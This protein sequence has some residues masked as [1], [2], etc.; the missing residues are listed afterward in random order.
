MSSETTQRYS[1][2]SK[3][4]SSKLVADFVWNLSASG[5]GVL[6][7]LVATP[8]VVH[9]LGPESYGVY[10]LLGVLLSYLAFTEIGLGRA[11]ERHGAAALGKGETARLRAYFG[12]ALTLQVVIGLVV[13]LMIASAGRWALE[14][15]EI[16]S[17]QRAPAETALKV[18]AFSFAINLLLG[19]AQAPLRA[20][21]A[22]S[23]LN[24]ISLVAQTV[25]TALTV[26][27][28][29][30]NPT[31]VSLVTALA[32][33]SAFRLLLV[34]LLS[35]RRVGLPK[36]MVDREILRDLLSFGGA[37]SLSSILSPILAH[38]EKLLL[39]ALVGTTTL[40]F[41]VVPF[42]VLSK[43]G[44]VSGSLARALFPLMS[45]MEGEGRQ[46][47]MWGTNVRATELLFWLLAPVFVGLGVTG[48]IL[49]S[50]WMGAEFA[51]RSAPVLP[52]LIGGMFINLLAWNAVGL[53]QA[54][55]RPVL[56]AGAYIIEAVLYLPLAWFLM[57]QHGI[58]GAAMAWAFRVTLDAGILWWIARK[59]FPDAQLRSPRSRPWALPVVALVLLL[60]LVLRTLVESGWLILLVGMLLAGGTF[61]VAWCGGLTPGERRLVRA[62]AYP[63]S[64]QGWN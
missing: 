44:L 63:S 30:W 31:V 48:D 49:L 47:S 19:T 54:R 16:S 56:V 43:F 1:E 25:T 37:L 39:S 57:Q 52:W 50:L 13:A 38:A 15:F 33:A 6:L 26:G 32:V 9:R 21:R 7:A 8:Y 18:I 40:T 59:L 55:G 64:L 14:L 62:K 42:R 61:V 3:D 5:W 17:E 4:D 10:A 28:A 36:P 41:Y 23:T 34:L 51:A 46:V 24:C 29:W 60:G 53:I 27:A 12:A 20:H 45:Q 2:V 35:C 58:V 11:V 22:F